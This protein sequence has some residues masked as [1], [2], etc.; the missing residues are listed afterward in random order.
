MFRWTVTLLLEMRLSFNLVNVGDHYIGYID[1]TVIYIHDT[2][3]V[4]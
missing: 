1:V 2:I 3:Y 4:F